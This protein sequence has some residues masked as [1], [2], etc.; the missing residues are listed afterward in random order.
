MCLLSPLCKDL[1]A[2]AV[3]PKRHVQTAVGGESKLHASS[4]LFVLPET[5]VFLMVRFT[6]DKCGIL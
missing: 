5:V 4:T 6:R 2:G 1:A 3:L